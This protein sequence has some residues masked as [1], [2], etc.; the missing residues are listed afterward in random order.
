[1]GTRSDRMISQAP[2]YYQFSSVYEGIQTA[3]GDEYDDVDAR[4]ADLGQQ[5]YITMATWGLMYWELPLKIPIIEADGYDIRRSRVLSRWR[6][7]ASQFSAKLLQNICEAFS[8]GEVAVTLDNA[9]YTITVTFVGTAGVPPNLDD[10][11]YAVANVVHAHVGT[12]YKFTYTTWEALDVRAMSFNVLD[13]YTWDAIELA[14]A[15]E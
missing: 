10:L 15:L 3:Q 12:V 7:I 8:G 5:L 14:L 4:D 13:T 1:M 2:Y 11:K 9:T 6:G